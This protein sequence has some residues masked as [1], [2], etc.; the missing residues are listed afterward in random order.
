M[1]IAGVNWLR[2]RKGRA[3]SIDTFYFIGKKIRRERGV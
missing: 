3:D 1:L 2:P